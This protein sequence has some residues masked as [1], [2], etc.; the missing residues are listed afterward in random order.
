MLLQCSAGACLSNSS[1]PLQNH[2]PFAPHHQEGHAGQASGQA[3]WAASGS[4]TKCETVHPQ[5]QEAAR[6]TS[7]NSNITGAESDSELPFH[8]TVPVGRNPCLP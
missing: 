8:M 3:A 5:Q 4:T 7:S 1:V 6:C 2:H